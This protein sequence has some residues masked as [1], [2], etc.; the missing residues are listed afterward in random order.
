MKIA[1]TVITILSIA[2]SLMSCQK[3]V[4]TTMHTVM[5]NKDVTQA[6]KPAGNIPPVQT[7][8]VSYM[9]STVASGSAD[10][11]QWRTGFINVYTVSFEGC[12]QIGQAMEKRTFVTG[13]GESRALF[14]PFQLNTVTVAYES[15]LQPVFKVSLNPYGTYAMYLTGTAVRYNSVGKDAGPARYTASQI[16]PIQFSV[17]DAIDLTASYTSPTKIN[18][19]GYGARL[20]FD[21]SKLLRRVNQDMINNA[22]VSQGVILISK[23]DNPEIY[24]QM[25]KNIPLVTSVDF[26]QANSSSPI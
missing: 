10:L 1:T 25:I 14:N 17:T 15:Y 4:K 3:D 5:P 2:S 6:P 12:V 7:S 19:G 9:M 8:S 22:V 21:P 11:I 16:V 18:Y 26:S 23:T 13:V 24:N 20:F